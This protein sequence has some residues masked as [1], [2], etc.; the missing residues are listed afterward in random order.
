MLSSLLLGPLDNVQRQPGITS[1]NAHSDC[2][3]T[4]PICLVQLS[5]I[6]RHGAALSGLVFLQRR[7]EG[8]GAKRSESESSPP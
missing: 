6:Y 4:E 8:R 3:K 5:A 7:K 2:P 1:R